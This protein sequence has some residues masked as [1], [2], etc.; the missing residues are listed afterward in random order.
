M[1]YQAFLSYNSE[2]KPAV[3][4][5]ARRLE[6]DG[7]SVFLDRW[8]LIPG[9]PWMPA[10]E[11]ALNDAKTCVFFIGSSGI[12]PWQNEE[13]CAALS[14]RIAKSDFYVVPV[15]LPGARRQPQ[16]RE[17]VHVL[18]FPLYPRPPRLFLKKRKSP[19]KHLHGE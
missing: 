17:K 1:Q 10:L 9:R 19:R 2:D 12:G 3:E 7:I 13:M 14:Q 4:E 5:I 11:E 6:Q 18:S 16:S 15:V 8:H